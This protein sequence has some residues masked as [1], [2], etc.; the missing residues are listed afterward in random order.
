MSTRA[1][2]LGD[3]IGKFDSDNLKVLVSQD[4]DEDANNDSNLYRDQGIA[5]EPKDTNIMEVMLLSDDGFIQ[6]KYM[7]S[8]FNI[9]NII[10]DMINK[11]QFI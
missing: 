2:V 7:D 11:I 5:L 10:R 3:W 4:T 8:T 1:S 9:Y 6:G